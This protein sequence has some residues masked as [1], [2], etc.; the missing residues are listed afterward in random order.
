MKASLVVPLVEPGGGPGERDHV[1]VSIAR[2]VEELCAPRRHRKQRRLGRERACRG[3]TTFAET[4]LVVQRAS[5]FEQDAGDALSV[6]VD[7]RR[8]AGEP[9]RG[10]RQ[11]VAGELLHLRR[12]DDLLEPELERGHRFADVRNERSPLPRDDRRLL[13]AYEARL[14]DATDKRGE[15]RAALVRELG[16]ER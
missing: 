12:D 6:E 13:V 2:E 7:P 10:V 16:L 5:L 4:A 14:Y 9:R 8:T 11:R 1:E 15:P 3:E